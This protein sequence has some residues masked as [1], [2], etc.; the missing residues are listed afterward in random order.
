MTHCD[1]L[2]EAIRLLAEALEQLKSLEW[3]VSLGVIADI[4]KFL[5]E[6]GERK[7]ETEKI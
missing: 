3:E 1:K 6:N 7:D 4:E 5:K 2:K